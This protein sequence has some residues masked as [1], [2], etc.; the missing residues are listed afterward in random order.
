M[1]RLE[2]PSDGSRMMHVEGQTD[3]RT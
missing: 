2:S 1:K 3:R